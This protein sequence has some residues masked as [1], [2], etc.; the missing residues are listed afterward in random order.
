M[1]ARS[2]SFPLR[3]HHDK[4]NVLDVSVYSGGMEDDFELLE[5]WRSGDADAGNRL[6]RRHFDAVVWFFQNKV[7]PAALEDLVQESFMGCVKSRDLFRGSARFRGFLL[8]VAHNVLRSYFRKRRRQG[9]DRIDFGVSSVLDLGPSPSSV[10]AHRSEQA[11]L[12]RALQSIPLD[13]QV[14]L[15][16]FYWETKTASEIGEILS[17][18]QGTVRTR[19][20]RARQLLAEAIE[21]QAT[22]P[23]LS[24]ATLDGLDDWAADLRA[25]GPE[26]TP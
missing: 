13:H 10:A 4:A 21:T 3:T 23:G 15:E 17:I 1:I 24:R 14:L 8:G 6:F 11:L 18:P 25:R 26:P 7:P 12:L 19:L 16:L 9:S 2:A 5:A 22:E 20:R